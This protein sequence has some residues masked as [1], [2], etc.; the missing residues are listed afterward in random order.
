MSTDGI[1]SILD[2][3]QGRFSQ[4]YG[5]RLSRMVLYGSYAR[6]EADAGSD[7]DILVVLNGSVDP[8][9]EIRRTGA[10]TAALSLQYDVLISC[11]FVSAERFES[12]E[13]PLLINVRREGIPIT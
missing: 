9:T 12:E 3:L 7:I 4:F 5:D 11:L 1:G 2:D 8:G 10:I 13:S 6:R